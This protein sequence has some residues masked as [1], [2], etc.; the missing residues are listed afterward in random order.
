M[1]EGKADHD[2][3]ANNISKRFQSIYDKATVKGYS[4]NDLSRLGISKNVLPGSSK[5]AD[6]SYVFTDLNSIRTSAVA[7]FSVNI[8]GNLYSGQYKGLAAIA[9]DN[10][11]VKKFAASGFKSLSEDG[12]VLLQFDEPVDVFISRQGTK[13]TII[14]ADASRRIKPVVNKF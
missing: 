2:F 7:S 1:I 9:A 12:K 5:N 3:G 14:V 4:V 10:N 13:Y 8:D 6:G 11:G